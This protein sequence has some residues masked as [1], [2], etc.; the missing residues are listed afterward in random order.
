MAK[1]I[2]IAGYSKSA[3]IRKIASYFPGEDVTLFSTYTRAPKTE[4]KQKYHTLFDQCFDL[5]NQDDVVALQSRAADIDCITCTQERDMAA[6]IQT[7]ELCGQITKSE[8]V[9]YRAIIDKQVMKDSLATVHP[10]L[11]P[12]VA[13]VDDDFLK[14]LDSLTYPQV[15]KPNGFTGSIMVK[16]VHSAEKFRAHYAAQAQKISDI[17]T[18]HYD[19]EVQIIAEEYIAG[20]QYGV[21]VYIDREGAVT[22]CPLVRVVAPQELDIDD[23]YSVLQYTTEEVS[24][25]DQEALQHAVKKV[26]HHFGIKNTSAHFDSV[27][28]PHGWK[29]FE[30]G[31]R[32]GGNRDK[33]FEYSHTMDHFRNDIYN[34]LGHHITIPE[35]IRCACIVQKA[36]AEPGVLNAIS[37]NRH[38]T[39][40]KSPLVLENKLKKI[41]DDVRP[42]ALG[43][44]TITRHFVLGTDE[45]DVLKTSYELFDAITFELK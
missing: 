16:V 4:A 31:L 24:L 28:T 44:G 20:P 15:M 26:V 37:Y 40:E 43:G 17:G 45:A 41:G 12:G 36:S 25:A 3:Y 21:N 27:L 19:K 22:F 7:L 35:R 38:I 8:A 30:V 2:L 6:Y 32:I 42:L 14:T 10:E 23:S 18:E 34:R 29:F 1:T 13:A 33:Q 9:S 39:K 5:T 11:V